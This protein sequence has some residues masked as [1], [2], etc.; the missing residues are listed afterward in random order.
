[1]I[2]ISG[3]GVFVLRGLCFVVGFSSGGACVKVLFFY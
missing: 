1:V 2:F 3:F